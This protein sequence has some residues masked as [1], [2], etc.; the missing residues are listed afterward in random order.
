MRLARADE[1]VAKLV[2]EAQAINADDHM[3]WRVA[4]ISV[5]GSYLG[6]KPVLGDL[7][8]GLSLVARPHA[9]N[10]D[11][12][13]VFRALYPAPRHIVASWFGPLTWSE[14][15]VRRRLRVGRNISFH[16]QS[17]ID[18]EEYPHLVLF[19]DGGNERIE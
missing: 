19:S 9:M 14:T 16:D 10:E 6:D 15:Y 5:F 12:I 17:E 4:L 13:A 3:L 18:H 8:I 11:E 7:D 1:I 2:A